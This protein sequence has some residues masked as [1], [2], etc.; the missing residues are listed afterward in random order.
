MPK[1]TD[2]TA[3]VEPDELTGW[4]HANASEFM[5]YFA[6]TAVLPLCQKL[7]YPTRKWTS[8]KTRAMPLY[9]TCHANH[10]TMWLKGGPKQ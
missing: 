9:P 4:C 1:A 7:F 6:G 2:T 8:G 5:H 10:T 3:P